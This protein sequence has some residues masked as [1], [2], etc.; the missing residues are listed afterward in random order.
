MNRKL[1]IHIYTLFFVVIVFGCGT[2]SSILP[3]ESYVQVK[4]G[5][6]WYRVFGEGKGTPIM[7]LHGGPVE[8]AGHF[9][10]LKKLVKIAP[11]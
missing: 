11:S 1:W 4:G 8:P 2:S 10:S 7:M 3:H 6:V 9:I 5:R